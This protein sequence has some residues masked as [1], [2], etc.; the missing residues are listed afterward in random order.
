MSL[1]SLTDKLQ[2][3]APTPHSFALSISDQTSTSSK[4]ISNRYSDPRTLACRSSW[5]N[6]SL[7]PRGSLQMTNLIGLPNEERA[8]Q[9]VTMAHTPLEIWFF[10][11]SSLVYSLSTDHAA[12]GARYNDNLIACLLHEHF[13]LNTNVLRVLDDL[14]YQRVCAG[15]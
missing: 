7:S 10:Q 2:P 13:E 1:G 9:N 15:G 14:H 12:V 5:G 11:R 8:S 6:G 3:S 4:S